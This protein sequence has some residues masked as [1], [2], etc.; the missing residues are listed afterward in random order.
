MRTK[1]CVWKYPEWILS[2]Y[3]CILWR[4][5]WLLSSFLLIYFW[6]LFGTIRPFWGKMDHF[7]IKLGPI[8]GDFW[9]HFAIDFECFYA[10]LCTSALLLSGIFPLYLT[11]FLP[12][13]KNDPVILEVTLVSFLRPFGVVLVLF[14]P[15]FGAPPPFFFCPFLVIL[16]VFFPQLLWMFLRSFCDVFP[17]RV[18]VGP[19]KECCRKA[20][21]GRACLAHSRALLPCSSCAPSRQMRP[22][23]PFFCCWKPLWR[24]REAGER[25]ELADVPRI[26]K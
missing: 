19:R 13:W 3:L 11:L 22:H 5:G 25:G 20:E 18:A 10:L 26:A 6:R 9:G 7:I 2:F 8:W 23:E 14:R 1:Q 15:H 4:S 17:P 16:V 12:F 21:D 24:Q